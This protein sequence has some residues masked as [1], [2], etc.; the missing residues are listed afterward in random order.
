MHSTK[1]DILNYNNRKNKL[2]KYLLEGK[3]TGI[4]QISN[5]FGSSTKHSL[6]LTGKQTGYLYSNIPVSTLYVTCKGLLCIANIYFKP[7]LEQQIRT[8]V[9]K[10]HTSKSNKMFQLY[11]REMQRTT[12]S[13]LDVDL[14]ALFPLSAGLSFI[15]DG[16][17]E[18]ELKWIA[19]D[20]SAD[21]VFLMM[22]CPTSSEAVFHSSHKFYL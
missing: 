15:T 21:E 3:H 7:S 16:T 22:F 17:N 14:Q 11:G 8:F 12:H 19:S 18:K 2:K 10:K 5:L 6:V 4:I 20:L 13:Q 9:Q 1:I